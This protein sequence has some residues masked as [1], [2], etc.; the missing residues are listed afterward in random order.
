MMRWRIPGLVVCAVCIAA[1]LG[2]AEGVEVSVPESL[3]GYR[4]AFEES[5]PGLSRQRGNG[6]PATGTEQ[7]VAARDPVAARVGFRVLQAGGSAADAAFAVGAA[8]SVREPWFS[9]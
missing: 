6:S 8:I 7:A 2:T 4:D 9:H 1:A 5:E 3:T